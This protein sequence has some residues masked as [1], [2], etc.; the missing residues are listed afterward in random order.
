MTPPGNILAFPD[1]VTLTVGFGDVVATRVGQRCDFA[2]LDELVHIEAGLAL[3]E[4]KAEVL[5][6]VLSSLALEDIPRISSVV[7]LKDFGDTVRVPH[8]GPCL[9]SSWVFKGR[10]NHPAVNEETVRKVEPESPVSSANAEATSLA[11][12]IATRLARVDHHLLTLV[13]YCAF[14]LERRV[15]L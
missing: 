4:I 9:L 5:E 6:V 8:C 13:G 7:H 1:T 15:T 12:E 2:V 10:S 11:L 3:G 14:K